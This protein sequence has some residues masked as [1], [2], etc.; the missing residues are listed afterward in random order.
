MKKNYCKVVLLTL[1]LLAGG[2]AL[3]ATP[4]VTLGSTAAA[5]A[6]AAAVNSPYVINGTG[7]STTFTVNAENLPEAIKLTATP[8]FEVFPNELPAKAKNIKVSVTL[9]STLPTT[10]GKEILRSGDYRAYVNFVGNGSPLQ[11]KALNENPA[12][13]GK[14]NSFRQNDF[15]PTEEGYTVEFRVKLDSKKSAFDVEAVTTAGAAFKACV[16]PQA[17]SIYNGDSKIN[18]PNPSSSAAGGKKLFYNN[19]GLAH[20][21]RFVMTSDRRIMAYRDGVHYSTL[22]AADYGNQ[23]TWAVA[24]GEL[25]E[26]LLKNSNFEGEFNYREPD[27]LLSRVEG[28]IVDPIDQYNCTYDVINKQ[29]N[30]ELDQDNHVMKLKR[31]NW[32]DGWGAGTVSQIVDVA[33]GETY[34]LSCLAGGG[35]DKKSGTNM[36]SIKI[37][38]VQDNTK[39]ASVTV[40]NEEGMKPYGLDYTTSADCRQIKVVLHNERFLNGGGWG[41]DP[42]D[43]LVD[44][45]SLSGKSRVLDQFVG[46]NNSDATLEYFTYDA[47][48]A[49]APLTPVIV[50]S[51]E[52]VVITGTGSSKTLAVKIANLVSA[53]KVS[54]TAPAGF[55]V[56][57]EELS[58]DSDG[59]VTVTLLSTMP[60]TEGRLVLRSGDTRAYVDLVGEGSALEQKIINDSPVFAGGKDPQFSHSLADGFNPGEAGYTVEFSAKLTKGNSKVDVYAVTS[61]DAAFKACIEPEAIS[62][63]NGTS[64]ISIQNPA[65]AGT[66]GSKL[67][68]NNDG[69][70]HVYRFAMTSDRRIMAYRD[71]LLYAT[72]RAED[73]GHQAGW[74][75]ADGEISENL[76]KN[77]DFEGEYNY[78]EDGL[79]NQ[80]QGWIVDPIDRYNCTY[81]VVPFEIDNTFD[82]N[83]HVMKLQ[84]YNWNDGWGS[85]T[86]SQIVDVVPGETYSLSFLAQGGMDKKSGT[87][88]S[89]VK[90]QEVQNSSKGNSVTITNEEG[91]EPYGLDYTAS[92]DCRQIKEILHNERFLN[93][94]GWGSNPV[95]FLVDN[96]VLTGKARTLDQLVGFDNSNSELGY[97]A[98]DVTGAY[99]PLSPGFG[100]DVDALD[101]VEALKDAVLTTNADGFTVLNI[102]SEIEVDVFDPLGR[103]VVSRRAYAAGA[104]IDLPEHGIYV[105]VLRMDNGVKS[106]RFVY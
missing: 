14:D 87:N 69:L 46:F 12:Y 6:R 83:N 9:L 29:I 73:Y 68:Y 21:F 65:T 103:S 50:P 86:V 59:E 1:S 20:T 71:G 72:L 96:M 53:G 41:S 26:N 56:F 102:P 95:A 22:R 37:Q 85:G 98:Y 39:G 10:T 18:I 24:D 42:V 91:M 74:A 3:G 36:S 94:G 88:M 32:N 58:A 99:A 100:D 104:T 45:M 40:T 76:L 75:V 7:N 64:K 57:P 62:I 33:P 54:V 66:G 81:D 17:I 60:K 31:Y 93:G 49:Y 2:S 35:M 28:W 101:E 30:K 92:A 77:A 38:E 106:I 16:E 55:S 15:N 48:G 19:D 51:E 67:F 52:R 11:Q 47:T 44:E 63:Y 61:S 43:F 79:L 90:I 13:T 34:S 78:R 105:A 82:H 80:V 97:F 70:M 4:V 23:K 89:S 84:R 5:V 25:S 8:G 27:T